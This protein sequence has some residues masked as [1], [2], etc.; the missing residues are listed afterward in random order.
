LGEKV[1]EALHVD[2]LALLSRD[3]TFNLRKLKPDQPKCFNDI[4]LHFS[5]GTPVLYDEVEELY[6]DLSRCMTEVYG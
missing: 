2:D 4:L 1:L 5:V 6:D 3:R